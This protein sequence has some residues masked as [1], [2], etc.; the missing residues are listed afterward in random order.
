MIE[1]SASPE[2]SERRVALLIKAVRQMF[3]ELG[4][5]V[6]GDHLIEP[7]VKLI[8]GECEGVRA[9]AAGILRTA[10]ENGCRLI[11]PVEPNEVDALVR[12]A[13]I[14]ENHYVDE[15]GEIQVAFPEED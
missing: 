3:N 10:A 15:H 13:Y 8:I 12:I 7:I 9:N 11:N 5:R 4:I 1:R 6:G 14:V 2:R